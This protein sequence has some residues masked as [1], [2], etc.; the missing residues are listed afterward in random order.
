LA[1]KNSAAPKRRAAA[2][3]TVVPKPAATSKPEVVEDHPTAGEVGPTAVDRPGSAT[4]E[5][6]VNVAG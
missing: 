6:A 2:K 5:P 1:G 3:A 4:S